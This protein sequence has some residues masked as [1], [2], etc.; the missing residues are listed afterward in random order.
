MMSYSPLVE[1]S[2]TDVHHKKQ[3][4]QRIGEKKLINYLLAASIFFLESLK[5]SWAVR[6]CGEIKL[7]YFFVPAVFL[8]AV[9]EQST[10]LQL[11]C[12]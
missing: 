7:M 2:F 3:R 11:G 5:T 8:T 9:R 6:F 1:Q 12:A 10:T 4:V